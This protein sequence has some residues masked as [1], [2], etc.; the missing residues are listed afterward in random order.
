MPRSAVYKVDHDSH[1]LMHEV[2]LL[3][4]TYF[5]LCRQCGSQVRFSLA[6]LLKDAAV[7]PFR[8][9]EIL[10]EYPFPQPRIVSGR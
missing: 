3:H 10:E 1:Q 6:R 9:T 8:S 7:L 2:T 4:G 5:P